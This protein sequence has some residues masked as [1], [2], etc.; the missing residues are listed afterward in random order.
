[1]TPYLFGQAVREKMAVNPAAL[2]KKVQS[3]AGAAGTPPIPSWLTNNRNAMAQA[4]ST[5]AGAGAVSAAAPAV[6]A[7][8]SR[9]VR[10]VGDALKTE[11][12]RVGALNTGAQTS[13]YAY[14][15]LRG[16]NRPAA[17]PAGV[18]RPVRPVGDALKTEQQRVSALNTGAQANGNYAYDPLRGFHRPAQQPQ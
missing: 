17:S 4:K 12:Q 10:P 15:P 16:F 1:M 9:P 2:V 8:G 13:G 6:P 5:A 3:V 18:S 14:D 11:Q 7:A